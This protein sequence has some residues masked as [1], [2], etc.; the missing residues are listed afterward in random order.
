MPGF[1]PPEQTWGLPTRLG[2]KKTFK[3]NAEHFSIKNVIK[4]AVEIPACKCAPVPSLAHLSPPLPPLLQISKSTP[5]TVSLEPDTLSLLLPGCP[6]LSDACGMI[7]PP[8][9][10][11]MPWPHCCRAAP[12]GPSC[13]LPRAPTMTWPQ[14][15]LL[16]GPVHFPPTWES[17]SQSAFRSSHLGS[18]SARLWCCSFS[19]LF[20]AMHRRA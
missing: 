7:T 19:T 3:K 9:P 6:L 18:A 20:Y 4:G 2:C 1:R 17:L 8:P 10:P 5:P 16:L 13:T 15:W 12:C 14:P 11:C